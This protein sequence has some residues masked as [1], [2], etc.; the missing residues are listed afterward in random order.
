M[1]PRLPSLGLTDSEVGLPQLTR[2]WITISGY[3]LS[4][5]SGGCDAVWLSRSTRISQPRL[6]AKCHDGNA[7]C[8]EPPDGDH[9]TS[10][11]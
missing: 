6:R 7:E 4:D 1:D 3:P 8:N 2:C 5:G 10:K 11:P 9:R